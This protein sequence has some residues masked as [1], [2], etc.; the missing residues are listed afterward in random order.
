MKLWDAIKCGQQFRSVYGVDNYGPWL[1]RETAR[2]HMF[3]YV[4]LICDYETREP[5]VT[6]TASQFWAAVEIACP[7]NDPSFI[8]MCSPTELAKRLGLGEK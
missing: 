7:S 3:S 4:D 6:I 2:D 1:D 8:T 5:T